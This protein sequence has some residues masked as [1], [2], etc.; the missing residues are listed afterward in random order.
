[1]RFIKKMLN[2]RSRKDGDFLLKI[3][4]IV[5]Q[6]PKD[7]TYYRKAFRH[8]SSISPKFRKKIKSNE[9]LEFLGDAILDAVISEF[10][11]FKYPDSNEGYLTQARS[12]LVSRDHLNRLGDC[13]D[14]EPMIESRLD[15]TN[16]VKSLVGNTF[17]ALIGA[18]YLDLGYQAAKDFIL[19][20]V[21]QKFVDIDKI[22]ESVI[23]YTSKLYEWVQKEK[24]E[25]KF[26]QEES[27]GPQHRPEFRVKVSIDGEELGSG[28]GDTKKKAKE[29]SAKEAFDKLVQDSE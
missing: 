9:R 28:T 19:T 13:L 23:S 7:A 16:K 20:Q 5:G 18:I 10:L 29:M 1:M 6:R 21:L 24:K 2:S 3:E 11:F 26:V 27:R 14:I 12:K 15:D 25:I 17:E 8:S 22:D 4:S